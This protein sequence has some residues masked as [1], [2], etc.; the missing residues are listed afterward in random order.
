VHDDVGLITV[1]S[2]GCTRTSGLQHL[3]QRNL[4][5]IYSDERLSKTARRMTEE[6]MGYIQSGARILAG[7]KMGWAT[8]VVRFED[9]E[10]LLRICALDLESDAFV[11]DLDDLL[12]SWQAQLDVCE[13]SKSRYVSPQLMDTIVVSPDVLDGRAIMEA[14]RYPSMVPNSGWWVFGI[15]YSGDLS[16]MKR[17][18]I[19]GLLLR[20][21][22]VRQ[23]LA[24]EPGFCFSQQREPL[25]WF[26]DAIQREEPS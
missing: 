18:H 8:S 3:G 11:R 2:P 6:I 15:D 25:V 21:N 5:L 26:E 17:I 4:E 10:K 7:E 22:D 24:L 1:R 23:Y 20:R 19:G 12:R 13:M 14:I 16:S 9:H